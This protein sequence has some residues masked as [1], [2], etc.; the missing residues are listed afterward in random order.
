[1]ANVFQRRQFLNTEERGGT[2]LVDAYVG[3][4]ND[5]YSGKPHFSAEFAVADCNRKACLDFYIC[6][7]ESADNARTKVARLRRAII[8]FETA[9]LGQLKAAGY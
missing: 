2:A 6:D 5:G 4:A 9:L 3:E 1:M 8:A 7:A